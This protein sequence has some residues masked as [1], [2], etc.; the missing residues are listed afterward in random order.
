[1]AFTKM[2]LPQTVEGW[3]QCRQT[4]A[5][6]KQGRGD[7]E[8]ARQLR[9]YA[10]TRTRT[11]RRGT[12]PR[13]ALR[14]RR[15]RNCHIKPAM[16]KGRLTKAVISSQAWRSNEE[17]DFVQKQREKCEGRRQTVTTKKDICEKDKKTRRHRQ[18]EASL[19]CT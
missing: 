17:N 18:T 19:A 15:D 9:R 2:R 1:M 4:T 13:E 11:G 7:A 8:A 16:G 5:G 6:E 3:K 10:Y 12:A 14:N